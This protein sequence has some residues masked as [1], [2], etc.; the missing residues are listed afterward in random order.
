MTFD[1]F[2]AATRAANGIEV[3]N[4]EFQEFLRSDFQVV[5]GIVEAWSGV[6]ATKCAVR[7]DCEDATQWEVTTD[8]AEIVARLE[9]LP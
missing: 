1:D 6:G 5:D 8:V 9:Q 2:E 7:I 3:S 4:H